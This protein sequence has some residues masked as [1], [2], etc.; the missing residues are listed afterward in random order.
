MK[1]YLRTPTS[2]LILQHIPFKPFIKMTSSRTER[3]KVRV[4]AQGISFRYQDFRLDIQAT[5][6]GATVGNEPYS[7][8]YMVTLYRKIPSIARGRARARTVRRQQNVRLLDLPAAM[9]K[10][11]GLMVEHLY[12]AK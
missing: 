6:P 4:N 10:V 9:S 8:N 7:D 12:G 3:T 5:D 11:S 1:R 2:T